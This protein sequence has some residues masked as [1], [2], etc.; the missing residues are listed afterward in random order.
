M[1]PAQRV[2]PEGA[3]LVP[4]GEYIGSAWGFRVLGVESPIAWEGPR[5]GPKG[6][7][8]NGSGENSR[9]REVSRFSLR[10]PVASH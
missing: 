7:R 9:D 5:G 2:P 4:H 3:L 10:N 1:P 6:G 8:P